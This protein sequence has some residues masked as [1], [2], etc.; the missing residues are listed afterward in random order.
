MNRLGARTMTRRT[1]AVGTWAAGAFTKGAATTSTFRGTW[2]P[3]PAREVELLEQGDR[4]RDPRVLYTATPLQLVAQGTGQVSDN[5]S[6]DGGTTWY[7]V[8]DDYDGTA[9]TAQLAPG[10]NHHRY[11][12]LR[13]DEADA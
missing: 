13:V 2:R 11:R 4:V 3:M 8:L 6:P 12:C 10:V 1:W 9:D 7:E 5:V